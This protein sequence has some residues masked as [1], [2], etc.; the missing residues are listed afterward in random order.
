MISPVPLGTVPFGTRQPLL[1]AAGVSF[2]TGGTILL[3]GVDLTIGHGERLAIVGPNG[4]G[5]T[6]LL[7]LLC[8]RVAPTRG[9]VRLDGR[10]IARIPLAERARR[11]AV[12]GQND[13][14]DARLTLADYVDLGRTPHR[15][16]G[17][18]A[19][20]RAAVARA[21]A[22]VGLDALGNRAVGTL[23]GGERQR[24]G[25]ARALAQEPALLVLDEPT[26]HL[27]PRARAD[28]LDLVR[29]LGLT[30]IA[31]LHDLA[32]VSPFADR[33]AVL[34]GGRLVALDRPATALGRGIVREVFAMD[35]FPV[36]NPT[37]G[38]PLLVFDTP[39]A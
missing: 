31:V 23:S 4:A 27:D 36:T 37:T 10:E 24:A 22:T 20:D 32:L 39:A 11:I 29:D 8:G 38:R 5:K 18:A 7:R 17:S 26:N 19:A 2:S 14:P 9:H 13:Q 28:L 15:A 16:R 33:V 34:Q 1:D 3:D 30:V 6:T 12:V 35:C 21:L 25:L